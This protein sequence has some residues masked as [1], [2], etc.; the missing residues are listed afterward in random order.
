MASSCCTSTQTISASCGEHLPWIHRHFV[1]PQ[2]LCQSCMFWHVID[3][4]QWL[5]TFACT[6]L[7]CTT[8]TTTCVYN[9]MCLCD[10]GDDATSI[11][12]PVHRVL[13]LC[14]AALFLGEA[15]G[16]SSAAESSGIAPALLPDPDPPAPTSVGETYKIPGRQLGEAICKKEGA[17][18]MDAMFIHLFHSPVTNGLISQLSHW[19]VIL[20]FLMGRIQHRNISATVY[21]LNKTCMRFP[22]LPYNQT[23]CEN[24][25]EIQHKH[26][27]CRWCSDKATWS[28]PVTHR[29]VYR[30][31]V[32]NFGVN[33]HV[34]SLDESSRSLSIHVVWV[35]EQW[36]EIIVSCLQHIW[37]VQVVCFETMSYII[38]NP[39]FLKKKNAEHHQRAR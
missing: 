18:L 4:H 32:M 39:A 23:C 14:Y 1:Q 33:N 16:S 24:Q 17:F 5:L 37:A 30:M 34:E 22:K 13:P 29:V 7:G 27:Y 8:S 21:A 35:I 28:W 2:S 3:Y 20:C 36:V 31:S 6:D 10:S 12:S 11:F 15:G 25:M 38:Y 26:W 9:C 19:H